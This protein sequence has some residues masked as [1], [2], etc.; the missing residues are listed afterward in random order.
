MRSAVCEVENIDFEA[1]AK[2]PL[3]IGYPVLGLVHQV[4]RLCR[5]MPENTATGGP[6]PGTSPTP[7]LSYKSRGERGAR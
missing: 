4:A 1:N 7:A 5:A 3:A 6:P 2:E